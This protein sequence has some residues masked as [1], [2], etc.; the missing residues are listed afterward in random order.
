MSIPIVPFKALSWA[1][2]ASS[3][4][5][6]FHV[7]HLHH[8]V[9]QVELRISQKFP[10]YLVLRESM[11]IFYKVLRGK[12]LK[13]GHARPS[14]FNP[15]KFGLEQKSFKAFPALLRDFSAPTNNMIEGSSARPKLP[16]SCL[17]KLNC[18]HFG[19]NNPIFLFCLSKFEMKN[20][21]RKSNFESR[22]CHRKGSYL[23][24]FILSEP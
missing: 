19:P 14:N 23:L 15:F 1:P 12:W 18:Q 17:C 16:A 3:T 20:F 9:C 5:L 2:V 7:I 11:K 13:P 22:E 6:L 10:H 24:P 8:S 21:L 4:E